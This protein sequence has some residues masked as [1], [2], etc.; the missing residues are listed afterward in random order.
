MNNEN[1]KPATEKSELRR[2]SNHGFLAALLIS[3]ILGSVLVG[4]VSIYSHASRE[5]GLWTHSTL[6]WGPHR[7]GASTPEEASER[8]E[9]ATDW[10][11]K[12]INA[13][14]TQR[15]RVKSVV[16]S[17]IKDLFPMKEQHQQNRQA[18]LNALAQPSVDR[19][20]LKATQQAELQLLQTASNRLVEAAADV[21]DVL[22]PEQRSQLIEHLSR[23]HR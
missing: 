13:D 17:A 11:L 20:A 19:E 22:T 5:A 9:F 4:S 10:I 16:Q 14:E 3:G 18:M 8:I 6:G 1:V 7:H 2:R 15:Q 21:A 12:R 23:F